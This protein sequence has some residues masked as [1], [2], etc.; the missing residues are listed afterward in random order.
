[1]AESNKYDFTKLNTLAV[2]SLASGLTLLGSVSAIITGHISLA[3]LKNSKESG[4]GLAIAGLVLGYAGIAFSILFA[5]LS[6]VL[7]ARHGGGFMNRDFDPRFTGHNPDNGFIYPPT[8]SPTPMPTY[9]T[10]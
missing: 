10:N 5:I 4:R 6:I 1:M 7:E 2:V 3:Q 8:I 9:T